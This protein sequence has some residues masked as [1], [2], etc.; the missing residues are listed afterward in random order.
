MGENRRELTVRQIR[1]GA[2]AGVSDPK[3]RDDGMILLDTADVDRW[4]GRPLGGGV[5]KDPIAPNDVRRWA[6]GMQN[7]NPLHFDELYAAESRFGRL[8]APQSFAV[9]TDTSHGAGPA[10]QGDERATS[11]VRAA[12]ACGLPVHHGPQVHVFTANFAFEWIIISTE[13]VADYGAGG[14]ACRGYQVWLNHLTG[15]IRYMYGP[16]RQE[17]AILG[18]ELGA[19]MDC[20]QFRI[21]LQ[22]RCQRRD[23]AGQQQVV[24][25]QEGQEI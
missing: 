3:L 2:S 12:D 14:L 20:P 19:A 7:P 22:D 9:C 1:Q 10:I 16:L 11:G 15:E 24:R 5:L 4:V 6:Q 13:G 18:D 21:C 25:V 23:K 8:V 17:A